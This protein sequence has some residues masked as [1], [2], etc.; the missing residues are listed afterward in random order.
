MIIGLIKRLGFVTRPMA[1]IVFS[2]FFDKKYLIGR[3]FDSGYIGYYWA[4][5]SIWHGS[6]LRLGARMPWP[7]ALGCRISNAKNIEFHPDDLNIFQSSGT[8][9]QNFSGKIYLG[10]GCYIAPNVGIITANHRIDAL[11][12]HTEGRDVKIGSAC[13]LGMNSIILPGVELGHNTIVGAGSVVTKSFPEGNV[14]IG[15]VPA[16]LIKKIGR[17]GSQ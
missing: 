15:G 13:W 3:H 4:I 9:F 17:P 10:K 1:K 14:I 16:V 12:E 5:K 11:D 6:V 8:Y 2:A 7:T